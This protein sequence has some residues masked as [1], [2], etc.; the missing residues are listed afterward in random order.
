MH[1]SI[2]ERYLWN[3][4]W[5]CAE[6]ENSLVRQETTNINTPALNKNSK[7]LSPSKQSIKAA[8]ERE[9]Q[10][11]KREEEIVSYFIGHVS[12]E[13]RTA[14]FVKIMISRLKSE[15]I[16]TFDYSDEYSRDWFLSQYNL[17]KSLRLK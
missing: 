3:C 1:P 5:V 6:T 13:K 11:R 10:Q 17:S 9:A 4:F 12:S 14:A 2:F 16:A 15:K 7:R 8:K